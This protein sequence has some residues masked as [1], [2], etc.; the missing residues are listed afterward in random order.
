MS[1]NID[2]ADLP[3]ETKIYYSKGKAI[4]RMVLL[5]VCLGAGI[6]LLAQP[7]AKLAGGIVCAVAILVSAINIRIFTNHSPQIIMS[8]NGLE[9]S[10]AP[11]YPW[12]QIDNEEIVRR[13]N[14]KVNIYYLNY[15]YPGGEVSVRLN[16]LAGSADELKEL[17]KAYRS[18]AQPAS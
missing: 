4:L 8:K 7:N 17:L 14:G 6:Y 11:F 10:K 1:S 2:N 15:S 5:L 18:N 16:S 9:S 3:P 12:S 13:F